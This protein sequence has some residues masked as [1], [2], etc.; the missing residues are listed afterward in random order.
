MKYAV[1]DYAKAFTSLVADGVSQHVIV[2]GLVRAIRE[3]SDTTRA[4]KIVAAIESEVV[5]SRGERQV[6]CEI[7]REISDD[8]KSDIKKSLKSDDHVEFVVN[9]ELVAGT[10]ITF[11]GELQLDRSFKAKLK[12]CFSNSMSAA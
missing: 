1:T 4:D 5:R 2:D 10:R 8:L 6:R 9:P 7:A 12:R 3:N 11:D